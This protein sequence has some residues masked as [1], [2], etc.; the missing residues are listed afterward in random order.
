[1]VSHMS[2]IGWV[3]RMAATFA[4]ASLA[5][6]GGTSSP[7]GVSAAP[8]V[9]RSPAAEGALIAP[10]ASPPERVPYRVV[11]SLASLLEQAEL[12]EGDDRVARFD[13]AGG[14]KYTLGGWGTH[15]HP[16]S[17]Q[18]SGSATDEVVA[19]VAST[20]RDTRLLLPRPSGPT[21]LSLRL[22]SATA[23]RVA[24]V[25][26]GSQLLD[27]THE[28][29]ESVTSVAWALPHDREN[30]HSEM[31]VAVRARRTAPVG[32]QRFGTLVQSF[33]LG[34]DRPPPERWPEANG[35][36]LLLPA[37]MAAQW[38]LPM[39]PGARLR[40]TVSSMMTGSARP[41]A[42]RGATVRI[43]RLEEEAAVQEVQLN[44]GDSF[45]IDLEID[46]DAGGR[47]MS[48][49]VETG[50]SDVAVQAEVV[51][52]APEAPAFTRPEHLVV[53][54]V[55]TLR[56][57]KLKPYKA[58]SRVQTPGL[59]AFVRRATTFA[60]AHSQENWTKP[61]VATLLTGLMP[62]EHTA[63]QH[64]SVLPA[65]VE[66][67]PEILK[68]RG[69]HTGAFIAN[70]YVSDRFGFG[71]G[72]DSYRNY[73]REGRRTHAEHVAGDVLAWLDE[74]P[75]D[76]P[77]FLY[78]HT[79][80]PHVPY[81]P[82]DEDLALY[83]DPDYRGIVDFSRDRLLLEN[84]KL[85][86]TRLNQRDRAQLEALYDGEITYHDRH[87][88]SILD[89]LERRGLA[90]STMVVVT[91]DHGEELFD[92][93]SVG[94]GHS[95]YEEL[96]HVPLFIRLP[97]V[98]PL[99][100]DRAVGL[101][102]VLP[103]I[104]DAFAIEPPQGLSG[105]SFLPS[106]HA[107]PSPPTLGTVGAFMEHWRTLYVGPWK[108]VERPRRSPRLYHLDND[109]DEAHD[110]AADH[111]VIVRYLRGLLG[112]QL[113]ATR[114]TPARRRPRPEHTVIDAETREQLRA[115]GYVDR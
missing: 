15:A 8:G 43:E 84:V 97:S 37:F 66:L 53:V 1:M 34:S 74:R 11:A 33:R 12:W 77:F 41:G 35:D 17:L 45:D 54:L 70:G 5:A 103:T 39:P 7:G 86:R 87:F 16:V 96:L 98:T 13:V 61:S 80:D 110:V 104:L 92:H 30:D 111:A 14:A 38:T 115:L 51:E 63:T 52:P 89:G 102:D 40:G 57:D 4:L 19:G 83:G 88:R 67:L 28:V 82:P 81:R 59:D 94:H 105:R 109:P 48:I 29:S 42:A 56:A 50:A 22:R 90:E 101:I 9:T 46:A 23:G 72:W 36:S 44:A 99:R 58:D 100:V 31:L 10:P 85:G 76:R 62:W 107:A 2:D 32:G 18:R 78:V 47:L 21:T 79:I 106:L 25:V 114:A 112:L 20:S 64:E 26:E 24:L 93:G 27:L 65:S 3:R 55:D 71:Q 113:A 69:F 108:L 6:C 75:Q 95:V 60:R 49:S 68:D 73:I 91:S